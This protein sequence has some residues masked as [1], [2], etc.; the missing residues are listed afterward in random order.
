MGRLRLA[1]LAGA[2]VLGA[3]LGCGDVLPPREVTPA[4]DYDLFAVL[5]V[6]PDGFAAER[7]ETLALRLESVTTREGAATARLVAAGGA[8]DLS[9]TWDEAADRLLFDPVELTLSGTVSERLSELGGVIDEALPVDGVGDEWSGFLRATAGARVREG[10][11]I[12]LSV[13]DARPPA[14]PVEA[15]VVVAGAGTADRVLEAPAGTVP[16][17]ATVE[18]LRFELSESTPERTAGTAAAGGALALPVRALP[19]DALLVRWRRLGRAG[20]PVLVPVP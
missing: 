3:G 13:Q 6:R 8:Q 9:G 19:G 2:L 18:V 11:L 12:G 10:T 7:F 5:R 17:G 15:F 14:P 4:S 16:E 1:V 20:P